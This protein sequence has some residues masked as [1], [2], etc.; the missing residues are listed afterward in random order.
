[1]YKNLKILKKVLN[2]AKE[3]FQNKRPKMKKDGQKNKMLQNP[4]DEIPSRKKSMRQEPSSAMNQVK[5][6][7]RLVN[8]P[9]GGH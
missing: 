9:Q 7:K 6:D 2:P 8:F 5:A 1:M 4:L 3:T